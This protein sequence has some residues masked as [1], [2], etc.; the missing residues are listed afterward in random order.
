MRFCRR[1]F[2][3][4]PD[5]P[6]YWIN[7]HGFVYTEKRRRYLA[8]HFNSKYYPRVD[9]WTNGRRTAF[10]VHRLV[11]LLFVP[12]PDPKSKIEVNHLDFNKANPHYKNLRWDT[13]EENRKH[14]KNKS[15]APSGNFV[16]TGIV[17]PF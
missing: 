15:W 9:L 1:W 14:N 17:V 16:D 7:R 13:P 12:N 8:K 11:A 4:I 5:A 10:F 2:K 3:P 6:G